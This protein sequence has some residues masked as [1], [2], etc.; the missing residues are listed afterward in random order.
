MPEQRVQSTR[1][2]LA[3]MQC[4]AKHVRC[5]A[6]KPACS[7]CLQERQACN[8]PNSRRGGLTR[9]LLAAHKAR[10]KE[11][12]GSSS[13][14]P[15][16]V[17]YPDPQ[18][19]PTSSVASS[20][21]SNTSSA[22]EAAPQTLE[23]LTPFSVIDLASTDLHNDVFIAVFFKCFHRYHPCVLP[24]KRLQEFFCNPSFRDQLLPVITAARF[25]GSIY[26]RSSFADQLKAQTESAIAMARQNI[27]HSPFFAQALL[28]YSISLFWSQEDSNA[29]NQ[30]DLALQTAFDLGMH[31][32]GFAVSYAP[33][34]PILQECFRRTWWQI[35]IV[36][37]AYAAIERLPAFAANSVISDVDLPCEEDEYESSVSHVSSMSSINAYHG[38]D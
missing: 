1:V 31:R 22:R 28:L 37:A 12:E 6:T 25:I 7:R 27:S 17:V 26:T 33:N 18:A 24:L 9:A 13:S 16:R 3:C 19:H 35:Y 36:D 15:G 34:D 4:R 23:L 2:S 14:L 30:M 5:D 38:N 32:R 8:Y 11:I 21:P 10:N 29:R 20:S